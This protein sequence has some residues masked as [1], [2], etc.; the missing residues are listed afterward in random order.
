MAGFPAALCKVTLCCLYWHLSVRS[1]FVKLAAQLTDGN[2]C[3]KN[4][5]FGGIL[6]TLCEKRIAGYIFFCPANGFIRSIGFRLVSLQSMCL[7]E[8]NKTHIFR[9]LGT[10]ACGCAACFV[11]IQGYFMSVGGAVATTP[12]P[13]SNKPCRFPGS[14]SFGIYPK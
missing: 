3:R 2:V 10:L 14:K 8:K 1:H 13:I 11:K 5:S 7:S 4:Q 12:I 6:F 9:P